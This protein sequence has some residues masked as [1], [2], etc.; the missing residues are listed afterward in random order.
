MRGLLI[1]TSI[2]LGL[3]AATFLPQVQDIRDEK[4]YEAVKQGKFKQAKWL[5]LHGK[6]LGDAKAANNYHVLDYR[7]VRDNKKTSKKKSLANRKKAFRAFDKLTQKGHIPAAYNAGM[8]YYKSRVGSS[9]YRD[10]LMYLDHAASEGDVRSAHAADMMRAREHKKERKNQAL[11]KSADKGNGL[12]AY[13]YAN[14]LRFDKGKLK[15][16]EKYSLM[17][18]Q[19]G[20]PDAQEFLASYF[21]RRGDKKDWLEKAAT[22]KN[23]RSLMAARDLADLA[24][25]E[26]D[27]ETKRKWLSIASTPREPFKYQILIEP[28]GLRWRGLQNSINADA[29]T[30]QHN[31]KRSL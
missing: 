2:V 6:L 7:I 17:G 26:R 14:N 9:N 31:S 11:R 25:K 21:P 10:G 28:E 24:D 5:Y 16:A 1:T 30:T 12:A 8:F 22:N 13:R 29:N 4:A 3:T 15:Y 18:A 27:F 23:N 20:Y 19:A